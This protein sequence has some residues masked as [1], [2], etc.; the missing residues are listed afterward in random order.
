M[1]FKFFSEN[2]LQISFTKNKKKG[3]LIFRIRINTNKSNMKIFFI[4]LNIIN[5]ISN[6]IYKYYI[7][8]I[9]NYICKYYI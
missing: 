5:I 7:N 2:Y 6:N 8:Y 1:Q 3:F 9:Y 4:I